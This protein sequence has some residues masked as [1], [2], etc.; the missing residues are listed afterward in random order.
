MLCFFAFGGKML[1]KEEFEKIKRTYVPA[2]GLVVN[3][4]DAYG[5]PSFNGAVLAIRELVQE[6]KRLNPDFLDERP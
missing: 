3:G 2:N 6:V 4:G 5:N 1:T